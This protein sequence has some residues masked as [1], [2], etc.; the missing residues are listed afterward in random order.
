[1]ALPL[2][3]DCHLNPEYEPADE[4]ELFQDCLAFEFVILI[5]HDI[6]L[7]VLFIFQVLQTECLHS[8][9]LAIPHKL[10]HLHLGVDDMLSHMPLFNNEVD[11]VHKFTC[12]N[13]EVLVEHGLG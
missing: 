10:Q 9:N 12:G 8:G 3:I 2:V 6:H 7:S 4:E 1:M 5:E 11:L 13:F